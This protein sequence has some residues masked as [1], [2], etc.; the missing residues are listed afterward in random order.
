MFANA[1]RAF[2]TDASERRRVTVYVAVFPE[3]SAR[4]R[5]RIS[6]PPAES[7]Q[8][9]MFA[10]EVAP[11]VPRDA[12]RREPPESEILTFSPSRYP[13]PPGVTVTV[14]SVIESAAFNAA[15][16]AFFST[17]ENVLVTEAVAA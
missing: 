12:A 3:T 16:A 6:P 4:V 5:R 8:L 11:I 7:V 13:V 17:E 15:S 1:Q 9:M 10:P 14:G 2:A